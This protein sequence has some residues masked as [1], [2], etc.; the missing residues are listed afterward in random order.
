[1]A[2]DTNYKVSVRLMAY[3]HSKYIRDAMDGIMMQ[4][5]TFPV[6]VVVGDDFSQDDTVE[7]V[8][9]YQSTELVHIHILDRKVGDEYWQKRQQ[10]GRLYNFANIIEHCNGKYIALLD[11]DDYWTD[12]L[13]LQKQVDFLEVNENYVA[14]YHPVKVV[15]LNGNLIKKSKNSFLHN[16]DVSSD[17]LMRGRVMS[18]LSLCFRNV[19]RQFPDEFFKSPTGD[20]FLCSLLGNH[21]SGK[22]MSNIEP[23]AYRMHLGG[24]WSLK[25]DTQKKMTLLLSYFWLWQYYARL[26]KPEYALV[27]YRKIILE[28]F[29]SNPFKRKESNYLDT[30]ELFIVRS[31]RR[32]F[33]L[34]KRMLLKQENIDMAAMENKRNE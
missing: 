15:D 1:M 20:N 5:T 11:G 28:G 10:L 29:Y 9:Q 8:R 7:I 34:L 12:P 27:F 2:S 30:A 14:C 26:G 16:R 31:V 24:T 25:D 21:G 18:T 6:E 13:K 19:I 22:Y 3:N 32:I 4:K 17:K 23:S 33:R